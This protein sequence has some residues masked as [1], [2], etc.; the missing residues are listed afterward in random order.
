MKDVSTNRKFLK[1]TKLPLTFSKADFVLGGQVQLFSRDLKLARYANSFTE[2]V[3]DAT[4]EKT[5][6]IVAP[7]L[8]PEIGKIISEVEKAELNLLNCKTLFLS[9]PT[10]EKLAMAMKAPWTFKNHIQSGITTAVSFRGANGIHRVKGLCDEKWMKSF[11]NGIICAE[12]CDE[13]HALDGLL[14]TPQ[15]LST[16][17]CIDMESTC[18]VIKPHIL[19]SR[20]CGDVLDAIL[21]NGCEISAMQLFHLDRSSAEEFYE[22]YRGILP[23][24]NAVVDHLCSGPILVMEIMESHGAGA[25]RKIV[26]PWDIAMAKDLYPMSIRA[27]FG[28]NNIE[29]AVHCTDL[30]EDGVSEIRYFFDVLAGSNSF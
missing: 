6:I 7:F 28:L 16:A 22:I 8:Y 10:Y 2:K 29:N 1:R 23:D 14:F 24:L 21:S 4:N 20:T 17:R 19:K 18:C 11:R 25:F 3:L 30:V 26:G 12:T 5:I 27:R 15:K 9:E 13:V